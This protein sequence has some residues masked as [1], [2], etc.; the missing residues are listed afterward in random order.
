MLGRASLV[1]IVP[2]LTIVTCLAASCSA[3]RSYL[4]MSHYAARRR[5]FHHFGCR[6]R[7]VT[8]PVGRVSSQGPPRVGRIYGVCSVFG[9]RRLPDIWRIEQAPNVICPTDWVA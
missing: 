3:R 5:W 8:A 1:P 2:S 4:S 6:S 7:C 9:A